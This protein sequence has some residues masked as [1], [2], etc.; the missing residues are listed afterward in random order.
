M[1]VPAVTIGELRS[2]PGERSAVVA[3]RVARA[4]R[5]QHERLGS[6]T[7]LNSAM[8][9]EEIRSTCTLD[10]TGRKLLDHAF[11]RLG[12]TARALDRILRVARTIADLAGNDSLHAAHLAE[13]IQYRALDRR[14]E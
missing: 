14:V 11:E 7:R 6:P 9:P 13:A 1:G 12:L 3:E 2:A 4:R 5:Q 8:T 10:P